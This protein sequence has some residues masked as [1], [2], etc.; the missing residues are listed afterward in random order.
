MTLVEF[1]RARS[2]EDEVDAR[3]CGADECGVWTT[4]GS[5]LDLCQMDLAVHPAYAAHM[6]RRDPARALV[7]V[8]AKRRITERHASCGGPSP[9]EDLRLLALPYAGH[10]DYRDEWRPS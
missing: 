7:E 1:L 6:A 8:E 3:R 2:D 5:V 4:D 9:C 10:A